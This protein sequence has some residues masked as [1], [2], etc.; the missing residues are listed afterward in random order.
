MTDVHLQNLD[1]DLEARLRDRAA[2]HGRSVEQEAKD[3]LRAAL[4]PAE[5]PA[6]DNLATRIRARMA[7]Y[8]GVDLEIPPREPMRESNLFA[9]E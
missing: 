9:D 4:A 1:G 3:I 8:G 6:P 5:G 2:S 7:P